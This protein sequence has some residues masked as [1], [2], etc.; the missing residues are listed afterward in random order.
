MLAADGI[1]SAGLV[2]VLCA[3]MMLAVL[4][5]KDL[6]IFPAYLCTAATQYMTGWLYICLGAGGLLLVAAGL[7]ACLGK[8]KNC[9]G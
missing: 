7:L 5:K 1:F 6:Y 9:K 4:H 3:V 2:T 8:G